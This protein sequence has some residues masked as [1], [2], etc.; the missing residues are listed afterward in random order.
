MSKDDYKADKRYML[1]AMLR[2]SA[3]HLAACQAAKCGARPALAVFFDR[4]E[5]TFSILEF[6]P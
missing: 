6:K 5:K 4:V 2:P 1:M 3:M